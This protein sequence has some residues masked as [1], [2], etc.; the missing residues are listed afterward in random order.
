M[1][2][3]V[4]SPDFHSG[5]YGFE[6]RRGHVGIEM[7]ISEEDKHELEM[8]FMSTLIDAGIDAIVEAILVAFHLPPEEKMEASQ[9]FV[10]SL[11][12][13][14]PGQIKGMLIRLAADE[15]NRRHAKNCEYCQYS[16]QG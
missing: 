8:Q 5:G 1:E 12:E 13:I 9:Q 7:N 11:R 2:Q 3:L 4:S 6:P 16:G 15:A 14:A 10:A